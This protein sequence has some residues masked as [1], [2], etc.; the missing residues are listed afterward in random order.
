MPALPLV[1]S[2]STPFV[3]MPPTLKNGVDIEIF[4]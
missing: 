2:T 4:G 3:E 1:Q